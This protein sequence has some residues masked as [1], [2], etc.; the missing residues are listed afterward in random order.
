MNGRVNFPLTL[1]PMVGLSH[2]AMRRL[3]RLYMPKDAATIWPTEMLNSR[4][5]P[6]ENL[7]TTP[8]TQRADD[9]TLL[10]PQIL[11][12]EEEPIRLSVKRL[13]EEWGAEGIDINMG[14]PVKKALSHNYG[15]ALMG[16]ASYAAEVVHMAASSARG[17]VSVKLRAG[18]QNDLDYLVKF[19]KG[20]EVAGASW[21][22]LHPRTTEQKRRG[23]ADWSQIR[24]L[25]NEIGIPVIGNGDIQT[26]DDV[27]TMI[28]STGADLAMAGRAL[29][30]RPWL[31]WQVG[32]RLGFAPPKGR[33]GEKAPQTPLEEGAEYGRALTH[34]AEFMEEVY[35]GDLG[36]RKFRFFVRTGAPWLVFGHDL[37]ARTTKAKNFVELRA[38]LAEFF[39]REQEMAARTDLRQ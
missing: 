19:V 24:E 23:S 14:C 9:E 5:V 10:V 31:F 1:A 13:E 28:H 7:K 22:T 16:D 35:P 37:Y 8:E 18:H 34:L 15:V 30:A 4:R 33:E 29:T 17:P 11:G 38:A 26:V 32:E 3:A 2:V 21:V 39:S 25:R 27:F 6:K 36:M 12:N 20:L